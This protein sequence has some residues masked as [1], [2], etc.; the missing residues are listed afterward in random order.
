MTW[1]KVENADVAE[2]AEMELISFSDPWTEQMFLDTFD[3][4]QYRFFKLTDGGKIV[5]YVCYYIVADS[6]AHIASVCVAP[7]LR[8]RGIGGE[9]M[10]NTVNECTAEGIYDLTLEVR[11]SNSAA[12]AL[13]ASCGFKSVGIRP[14][15]YADGEDAEIMWL[16][17]QKDIFGG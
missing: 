17:A 12:L 4:P 14:K 1:S 9:L 15:Y 5:G 6:E 2:I 3:F 8:G 7:E 13:Y 11:T 16:N 10:K